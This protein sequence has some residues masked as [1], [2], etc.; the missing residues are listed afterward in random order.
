[1]VRSCTHHVRY[2]ASD[3]IE[4]DSLGVRPTA[5]CS[6][7]KSFQLVPQAKIIQTPHDGIDVSAHYA[8]RGL[9][10][11][12]G[13]RRRCCDALHICRESPG[14][15]CVTRGTPP[16]NVRSCESCQFW[17]PV[18]TDYMR[19]PRLPQNAMGLQY[20]ITPTVTTETERRPVVEWFDRVEVISLARRTDRWRELHQRLVDCDWPFAAVE[21]FDAIDGTKCKPP[22]SW[23][24]SAGAWGC[25]RSHLRL[26][27]DVIQSG[28]QSVLILEDDAEP[29]M[30]FAN[31][32][33]EWKTALPDNWQGLWFG[34]EHVA[35]MPPEQI[36]PTTRKCRFTTR[37]HAFG[38]R[39]PFLT[40]VYEYLSDHVTMIQNTTQHIDHALARFMS[41]GNHAIYCPNEWLVAQAASRS[42][43]FNRSEP[44]RMFE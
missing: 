11:H 17:T 7:C 18:E 14:A 44:R 20:S 29:V 38:L 39:E 35:P 9:C 2:I 26:L 22:D 32:V 5:D 43:I 40:R 4:C 31:R 3:Q 30:G 37:T 24:Q 36:T 33:Y 8:H 41:H 16:E 28:A 1:M 15:N 42:D 12:L 21:R 34:G 23:K 10:E 6:G 27:E 13:S 25:Y 19:Y